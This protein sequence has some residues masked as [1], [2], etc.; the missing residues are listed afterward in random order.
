MKKYILVIIVITIFLSS[1][2]SSP[3]S[4][5]IQE[6]QSQKQQILQVNPQLTLEGPF[7]VTRII[8]GDTLQINT[9]EKIRLS[10]INTPETGECYYKEA[11]NFLSLLTL[12]Q[13]IY[14]ERDITNKDVYGRLLR[15]IYINDDL[16]NGIMV[17]Q[18]YAKVYDKYA[19]DTKRY[20]QLKRIEDSAT[21]QNLGVWNCPEKTQKCLYMGS[22][23]SKKYYPPDCKIIKRIKPENLVCY[24]LTS[25]VKKLT[26]GDC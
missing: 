17:E 25:Q 20:L 15:Y 3:T 7:L 14:L 21:S 1:C 13:E 24:N 12:N 11:K 10:G 6:Q 22:K 19:N 5:A 16:I 18:G 26:M 9:S 2:T 4:S 23:N 8:D